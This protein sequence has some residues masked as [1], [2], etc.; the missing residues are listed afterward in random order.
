MA[1]TPLRLALIAGA[2]ALLLAACGTSGG[3]DASDRP[4]TTAEATST[5]PTD[6]TAPE[7][8]DTT[9]TEEPTETTAPADEDLCV[10]LKVLSDYDIESARLISVGDWAAI[11]AFFVE[12]TDSV[13]GAYDDAIALDSEFTE[14]L[15]ALRAV[16]EGT[17]ELAGE[18]ND[19][20]DLSGKLTSL[21]GIQEAGQ[22]GMRVN[23]YAEENCGFS[24]GGNGQ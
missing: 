23:E 16:S 10:P 1:R 2:A 20:M 6:T 9:E 3:D 11:Q 22:A 15:E 13:L 4:T 14:D 17:A 5:A 19:L 21:P 8:A 18:S 12:E 7:P 24:T